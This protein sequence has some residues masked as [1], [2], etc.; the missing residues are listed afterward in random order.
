MLPS[1]RKLHLKVVEN[2]K[3]SGRG[4]ALA[5]QEMGR[6]DQLPAQLIL[7]KLSSSAPRNNRSPHINNA[8]GH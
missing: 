6:G 3:I 7:Q 8:Y 5:D 1:T 2:T 4:G